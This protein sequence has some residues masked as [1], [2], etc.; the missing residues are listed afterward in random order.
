MKK[1][2]KI[3]QKINLALAMIMQTENVITSN[4]PGFDMKKLVPIFQSLKAEIKTQGESLIEKSKI[5]PPARP[6]R[7]IAKE[8]AESG[9]VTQDI[10]DEIKRSLIKTGKKSRPSKG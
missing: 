10:R 6:I 8:I 4:D 3:E 5:L 1:S 2:E 9:I 7:E